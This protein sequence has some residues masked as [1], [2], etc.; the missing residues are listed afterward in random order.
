MNADDYM[1]HW[2]KNQVWTHLE[3]PK[4]QER[5]RLCTV[6]LEGEKFLDVGCA[7]GHS[8]AIMKKFKPGNW[9]GMD[10]SLDAIE[11]AKKEF[12]NMKFYY[13]NNVNKLVNEKKHKWDSVVCSEVIE[14]VAEDVKLMKG[15][16]NI[17]KK[18]ICITTPNRRVS[19]PGHLRIYTEPMLQK[20]VE[21]AAEKDAT[22]KIKSHGAFWYVVIWLI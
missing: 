5:L 17:T 21:E 10:F 12:P 9:E 16:F 11:R 18:V 2:E 6:N 22:Y 3:W 1:K 7:Y 4:H 14:H 15:L 13:A 19:D 8:T 20:V